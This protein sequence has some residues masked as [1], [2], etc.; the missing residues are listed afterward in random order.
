M[1]K[2]QTEYQDKFWDYYKGF[3]VESDPFEDLV[4]NAQPPAEYASIVKKK[5][6]KNKKDRF[7]FKQSKQ[8]EQSK[9]YVSSANNK[10]KI[11]TKVIIHP[12]GTRPE[13]SPPS[14]FD[15]ASHC[16]E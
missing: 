7:A 1:R 15:E 11:I 5:N 16:S 6:N 8:I 9:C 3:Q 13:K 2:C 4:K 14:E 12:M 10:M